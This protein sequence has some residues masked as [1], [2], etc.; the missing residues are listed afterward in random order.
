[1][2]RPAI[3]LAV[4]LCGLA[5]APALAAP[6]RRQHTQPLDDALA[7]PVCDTCDGTRLLDEGQFGAARRIFERQSAR[8]DIV[9]TMNLGWMYHHGAGLTVN[10]AKAR[11]LYFKAA[12]AGQ[13]VAMNQ[14]GF[15]YQ[16]GLGVPRNLATAYC[17]YSFALANAY[18]PAAR[19]I[20]EIEAEGGKPAL[21]DSGCDVVNHN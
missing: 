19:H 20:A 3:V 16:N 7:A 10:Y 5:A 2:N 6:S 11:D 1:M 21:S 14:M 8:G 13:N 9:A 18:A 4:L 15:L 12:S 17:W